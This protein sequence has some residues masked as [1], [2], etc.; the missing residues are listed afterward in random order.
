[1]K[2]LHSLF[3]SIIC[4]ATLVS[5]VQAATLVDS[6]TYVGGGLHPDTYSAL[7]TPGK[8]R[9]A[10]LIPDALAN[11]G[12]TIGVAGATSGGLGSSSF[13][14]GYEFYY[15]FF[16]THVDFTLQTANVLAGVD[17]ITLTFNSGGGS[18]ANNYSASTLSLNYNPANTSVA[19]SSFSTAPGGTSEFGDLTIYS[20]TW[21]VSGLGS[22]SGF[23][24]S[25]GANQ[26]TTLD[27]THLMQQSIP[28]PSSVVLA[29]LGVGGLCGLRRRRN[30]ADASV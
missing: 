28:E 20:W 12:A 22:S 10:V 9:P 19:A 14:D 8:Y 5:S 15:T 23:S 11:S 7:G 25:W 17:T 1:M 18:P 21:N 29:A 16:S 30:S 27:D 2:A 24:T 13:P 26:H 6:W 3:T 4:G